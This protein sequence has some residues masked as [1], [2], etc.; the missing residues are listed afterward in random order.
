MNLLE[1]ERFFKA[2]SP[3]FGGRNEAKIANEEYSALVDRFFFDA[4]QFA[5]KKGRVRVPEVVANA[6]VQTPRTVVKLN[7]IGL[8][9]RANL[10]A[11]LEG[12]NRIDE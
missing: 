11:L 7:L 12:S 1:T 5:R 3:G 4:L 2:D 6:A 8:G 10:A 9:G